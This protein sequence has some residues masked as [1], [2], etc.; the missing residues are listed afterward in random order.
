MV[1]KFNERNGVKSDTIKEIICR[2]LDIL[3]AIGIPFKGVTDRCKEQMALSCMALCSIK[4]NLDEPIASQPLT[5]KQIIAVWNADY[6][7]STSTGSYDSV[8]D[9]ALKRLLDFGVIMKESGVKNS[10]TAGYYVS[11]ELIE[12]IK[13]FEKEEW[14]QKLDAFKKSIVSILDNKTEPYADKIPTNMPL[15]QIFFGAPGTGKSDTIDRIVQKVPHTRTTFHP[16]SD[17][18]S[19]VGAY[20]PTMSYTSSMQ[21][22]NLSVED[23]AQKLGTYYNDSQLGKIGGIQKF[24]LDFYPYIDGEY[25]SVNVSKLLELAGVSDNYGVEINKY[26]KFCRMLPKRE[27]NK[28]V[29]SFT[30]QAFLK[31]YCA[32]WKQMPEPYFLVIEE[33]NRGN[34]AQIFGDLFQLLDRNE[35]GYSKYEIA[36]DDD[37]RK[38][39]SSDKKEGFGALTEE[40]KENFPK[41]S[42]WKGEEL[43]L[44]PNLYIWATMNTSDQSLFPIDSAFKRRWDWKY[45]PIADAKKNYVIDVDGDQYDWWSFINIINTIIEKTIHS[46]DKKLGYFFAKAKDG[47]ISVDTFVSKVIFYLW[48]DVFKDYDCNHKAFKD[49]NGELIAFHKF[50]R[51]DGTVN[52][53]VVIIFLKDLEVDPFE[54]SG[55]GSTLQAIAVPNSKRNRDKSRYKVNNVENLIKSEMTRHAFQTYIDTHQHVDEKSIAQAWHWLGLKNCIPHLVETE[56]DFIARTK[57][58]IDPNKRATE[59]ILSNDEKIYLSTQYGIGNIGKFIDAVNNAGW[60][61]R[62]EKM[63]DKV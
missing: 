20:K 32:A 54:D 55:N 39:L 40:Q 35:K 30:P 11:Q 46:E 9:G 47:V 1:I 21:R 6:S 62:I 29:Y 52:T 4:N 56:E 57:D 2:T 14:E 58:S 42:V 51:N 19:F 3:D 50:Y 36:P 12:L 53:D 43:I 49:E 27:D 45:I 25:M 28:I 61:I 60:N 48:N 23:L 7:D 15:Q 8:R 5:T 31:A 13:A 38:F 33:I 37:I 26:L 22:L 63:P 24:C 59:F 18:A 41:E 17:Y 34:C 44:P 16:D 10:S